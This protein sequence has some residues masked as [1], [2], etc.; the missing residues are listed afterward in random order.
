MRRYLAFDLG[1]ESGRAVI[2]TLED[3]R[4]SIEELHRFANEPVKAR[5]TLHWDVLR[6]WHE[7]RTGLAKAPQVDGIGID[8]WGVD[9]ALLDES[10][11]LLQNPVHY[12]DQRTDG[13]PE[14]VFQHVPPDEI[15]ESTGVQFMQINTLFQLYALK[16]KQPKLLEAARHFITVPDL[17]NYWL[18]GNITCEYTNATTTQMFDARARDWAW[19][20]LDRLGLPTRLLQPVTEPGSVIGSFGGSTVIAPACHDTGSA[21]AAI[22][23]SG[24]TAFISSGTWSLMGTEAPAPIVTPQARAFNFTN[25]GGV[26][27]TTRVLKNIMGMWLLQG[28]RKQWNA[29]DYAS[30]VALAKPVPELTSLVDPDDPAFL[31]PD[32]MTAAIDNFCRS[33]NQPVPAG[34]AAYVQTIFESLALKYRYVLESLSELTGETYRTIRV[35]G[36]GARNRVLNQYLADAT[37]CRVLAG[38]VE[39]TALGNLVMQMVGSGAVNS[40]AEGRSIVARSF[41]ADV[42]KPSGAGAWDSAYARF[43]QML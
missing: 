22:E 14:L 27:G 1:A 9:F 19:P 18:T 5:E 15:Y 29:T 4:L 32:D 17:L 25:E 7:I 28:C 33:T 43:R 8:T 31:H 20:M 30:L 13:V 23:A 11:A 26:G 2:G 16:E 35:V 34:Q 10:G 12:R 39:A 38:P 40:I 37:N 21:V 36:G 6:L 42:Y 24:D 3:G 41:P